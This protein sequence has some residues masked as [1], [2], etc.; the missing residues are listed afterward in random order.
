MDID[1]LVHVHLLG[2][3]FFKLLEPLAAISSVIVA[4]SLVMSSMDFSKSEMVTSKVFMSSSAL[5]ID[6]SH[7]SVL[8]AVIIHLLLAKQ[9]HHINKHLDQLVKTDLLALPRN[10]LIWIAEFVHGG[11]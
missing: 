7:M 11:C 5:S 8:L 2:H 10:A 3:I 6:I 1:L 4:I 9:R